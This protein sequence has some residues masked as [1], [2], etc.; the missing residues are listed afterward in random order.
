ME[1][2][3]SAPNSEKK[4]E[5]NPARIPPQTPPA[6]GNTIAEVE[7]WGGT[8]MKDLFRYFRNSDELKYQKG[9]LLL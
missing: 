6:G 2:A 9:V 4:C 1:L 8:Q 3:L 7:I 5:A